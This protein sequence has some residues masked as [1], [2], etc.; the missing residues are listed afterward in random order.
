[1][2]SYK[3]FGRF[4]GQS[5]VRGKDGKAEDEWA[6][7][8]RCRQQQADRDYRAE[9]EAVVMA[10]LSAHPGGTMGDVYAAAVGHFGGFQTV[11]KNSVVRALLRL[12]KDG[13]IAYTGERP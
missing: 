9:L 3:K 4:G 6:A 11:Q 10:Y 12:E 13:R 7:I 2:A 5:H 8:L 1:M